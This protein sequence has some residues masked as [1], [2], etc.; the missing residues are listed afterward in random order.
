MPQVAVPIE[1]PPYHLSGVVY[2]TLLNHRSA[3]QHLGEA[4]NQPPYNEPPKAPVLYVKP[5]NTLAV[6]GDPV[7]VPAGVTELELEATLGLVIGR[8][9]C[10][11]EEASALEFIAGYLIVNDVSI[12]HRPYYRPSIP[13]RARDGFCPIG[14]RVVPRAAVANPDDLGIR[15]FIDGELRQQTGTS[16]LVRS[17]RRLLADVTE[18]MTLSPGDILA[19]GAAAP[20]PRVRAG[21]Q[22]RIEIDGIGRLESPF[23]QGPA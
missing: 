23:V 2:A 9:A 10:R 19:V 4:V 6:S 11:L 20:A 15:V 3:W 7:P 17:I 14:P 18:F 22:A 5:R 13:S 1:V 21:Q 8:P 16:Q 12:P